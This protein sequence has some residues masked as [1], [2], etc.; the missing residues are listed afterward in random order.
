MLIHTTK[1]AFNVFRRTVGW[2]SMG[3]IVAWLICLICI[4]GGAAIVFAFGI[5]FGNDLV[6]Q[7]VTSIITSIFT[8]LL[9]TQPIQVDDD[10]D[11][12]N[13]TLTLLFCVD[14]RHDPCERLLFK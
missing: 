11:F 2:P 5:S 6:H 1:L 9:L 10:I 14:Y 13:A 8:S 7:W 3:R 4:G 12:D